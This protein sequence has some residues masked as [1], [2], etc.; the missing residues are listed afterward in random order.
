MEG[1]TY[2]TITRQYGSGGK[3]V[4]S[5]VAD[6]LGL[7]RYDRKVVSLAAAE[8]GLGGNFEDALERSYNSPEN[9]LGNLGDYAYERVPEHNRMYIEQAKVILAIAKKGSAVFLGRCADYILKEQPNTYSFFIYADDEFRL[10]RSKDHYGNRTLK[11]LDNED[12]NRKRYY[13]YYTGQLWGSPKNYD[14]MINTSHI[15]LETAADIIVKYVALRQD[16]KKI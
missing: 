14:L 10:A 12:K 5:L 8:A 2:I 3:E 13:S 1:N 7:R 16:A 9:C 6:K 15:S 11:E 4:S